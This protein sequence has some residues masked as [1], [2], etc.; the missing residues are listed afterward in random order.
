[1]NENSETLARQLGLWHERALPNLANNIKCGNSLIGPDY[2]ENN[3]VSLFDEKEALRI[4]VF[5][6]EKEFP[7][8]FSRSVGDP[9]DQRRRERPPDAVGQA[10]G[11][12]AVI[13]NP[14]YVRQE[15]IGEFKEYFKK[16]YKV[17]HGTADLYIYFIEKG[18]SFLRENGHFSYI[19]ANKWMR[20]NYG[21]PF[22]QWLKNQ[23]IDEI[24]DFGDLPV[25]K[26][27]TTYPCIL[28]VIKT[29]L[30]GTLNV[31]QMDSLEFK[32]LSAYIEPL[33]YEVDQTKLDDSGWSLTNRNEQ[34][35][36]DRLK[37]MGIP[38]G[39]YVDGKIYRGILTGLN[40]AFVISKEK[41]D[42][43]IAE[44]PKSV[45][46]IRPFLIGKEIKR[47]APLKPI[48][49]IILI[50]KGWTNEESN[51]A[52]DTWGWMQKEYPAIASHL[53]SYESKAEKR[54]DKGDYWWELRACD[55]YVEF[56]KPKLLLPDISLRGNFAFDDG[57]GF[58]CVNTAY[59]IPVEDSYLMGIL[60]SKLITFIY[61]KSS[62]VFRGGYLRFI[63]Q[64]LVQL[65]IR[66]ID[67][68]DPADKARHDRMVALVETMLAL[69]KRLPE[70]S[71]PQEKDVIQRQ[72]AATDAQIDKLVYELYGLTKEEIEV[73]E[74]KNV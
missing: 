47:Y 69:H 39:N 54:W 23:N 40:E 3:Q 74:G 8:I 2:Y 55:Y 21:R 22:R 53:I 49:F 73:V 72:I 29:P 32:D 13:G 5:D 68:S 65:P 6:W 4:N 46:L 61:Q 30:N 63:Y 25:F 1:E 14:P 44:D 19:V 52:K 27:V 71:T 41:R 70:V 64:Y 38:L 36:L 50:P 26:G 58:Y 42:E 45:E 37:S 12:D 66:V 57:N 51:F 17:Y 60:N 16:K 35:L 59:I 9:S 10:K 11:F 48:N 34:D 67:F 20:A 18:I 62:A 7:E 24:I 43:L 15:M 31:A 56:E 28:K 33:R